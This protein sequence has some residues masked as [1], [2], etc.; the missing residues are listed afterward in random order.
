MVHNVVPHERMPF[1]EQLAASVLARADCVVTHARSVADD[2]RRLAPTVP[3]TVTPHPPNLAITSSALPPFPPLR[4]L[5]LGYVRKY[6]GFDIAL[7]A[8][9]ILLRRGMDVTLTVA[10][11]VWEEHD[12][13]RE[14][15]RAPD[16]SGAC[17]LRDRYIGDSELIELLRTHHIVLLP[18]R[19][20]TQSGI[21]PLAYAAGRPVAASAVGGLGEVVADGR[22]GRLVTPGN[23]EALADAVVEISLD[24]PRY[25]DAASAA[26]YRWAD[27]ADPFLDL[28]RDVP[29]T[30]TGRRSRPGLPREDQDLD[31]ETGAV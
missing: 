9:R 29:S 11:D 1:D 18:Y 17:E 31:E 16:V 5:C 2:V 28:G 30:P 15:V 27:V 7:E 19:D 20:A 25:A 24:L 14:R 4:L 26:S 10:G 23:P 12:E 13:W 21:V 3:V 6:K 8:L 22:T